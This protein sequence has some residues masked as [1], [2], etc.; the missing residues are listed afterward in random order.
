MQ[1]GTAQRLMRFVSDSAVI[2][3]RL[4]K[5]RPKRRPRLSCITASC[6]SMLLLRRLMWRKRDFSLH[7]IGNIKGSE[8]LCL[9]KRL[10]FLDR[11]LT[12]FEDKVIVQQL[13]MS[14]ESRKIFANAIEEFSTCDGR[15]RRSS[16]APHLGRRWCWWSTKITFSTVNREKRAYKQM[17]VVIMKSRRL[18]NTKPTKPRPCREAA[19]ECTTM[20]ALNARPKH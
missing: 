20:R 5:R 18:D 16:A 6:L 19:R 10:L 11:S 9:P 3:G 14:R 8:D 12:S 4:L 13:K 15:F 17:P 1:D 2:I 7:L